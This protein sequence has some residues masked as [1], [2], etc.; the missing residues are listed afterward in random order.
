[1]NFNRVLFLTVVIL[2]IAAPLQTIGE[3]HEVGRFGHFWQSVQDIWRT[4]DRLFVS[5]GQNGLQIYDYSDPSAPVLTHHLQYSGDH[6]KFISDSMTAITSGGY[7]FRLV[8]FSNPDAPTM[9]GRVDGRSPDMFAVSPNAIYCLYMEE[10]WDFNFDRSL[11]RFLFSVDSLGNIQ[12]TWTDGFLGYYS[13]SEHA[14]IFGTT[15]YRTMNWAYERGFEGLEV[16]NISDPT[17]PRLIHRR[18]YEDNNIAVSPDGE[19]L[20]IGPNVLTCIGN[21]S[22]DIYSQISRIECRHPNWI[23]WGNRD[24]LVSE[25]DTFSIWSLIAP[26]TPDRVLQL[27][28][29]GVGTACLKDSI[30]TLSNN[31]RITSYDLRDIANPETL[32]V[33]DR[34]GEALSLSIHDSLLFIASS[35]AG[36]AAYSIADPVRPEPISTYKWDLPAQ[37]VSNDSTILAISNF[38][39]TLVGLIDF[40]DI[41]SPR[42]LTNV[43]VG[44]HIEQI[45]LQDQCLYTRWGE[46]LTV[47]DCRDVNR[48]ERLWELAGRV[49]TFYCTSDRLFCA[50]G[51]S[52]IVYDISDPIHVHQIASMPIVGGSIIAESNF[53]HTLRRVYGDYYGRRYSIVYYGVYNIEQLDSPDLINEVVFWSN[54]WS[55]EG[56]QPTLPNFVLAEAHGG[57]ALIYRNDWAELTAFQALWG[58]NQNVLS[59]IHLNEGLRQMV[60]ADS[61]GYL[62]QGS[63]VGIFDFENYLSIT[64]EESGALPS[65]L[66]LCPPF[67]NPFNSSTT[68]QFST[69]PINREAALRVYGVD[70]RMVKELWKGGS[71]SVSQ[72]SLYAKEY[73]VIWDASDLAAGVYVV[74]LEA[75]GETTARKIVLMK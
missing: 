34:H 75:M 9:L 47:Y 57:V 3:P 40:T 1:M 13:Y 33:I 12:H 48:I 38:D 11:A 17:S 25:A 63:S 71:Q 62:A 29:P 10:Y 5:T 18:G 50:Q 27:P 59:Q 60:L 8:N 42:F 66:D 65:S 74:R 69:G 28:I 21:D 52:I 14:Q 6:Y 19:L 61:L 4:G 44:G 24:L 55:E 31:R 20:V 73:K 37:L 2:L 43:S 58:R 41:G 7:A 23:G 45:K 56:P 54:D 68:I 35:V 39:S 51:N 67:P 22:V 16:F 30:L 36:V 64:N 70:G 53:L 49:W 15:L 72:R 32:S 26:E 46:N